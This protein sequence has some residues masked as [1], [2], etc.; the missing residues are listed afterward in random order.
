MTN[1]SKNLIDQI[2]SEWDL[3]VKPFR[4]AEKQYQ[5]NLKNLI[6]KHLSIPISFEEICNESWKDLCEAS[7]YDHP[8]DYLGRTHV[9][10]NVLNMHINYL[11]YADDE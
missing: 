6:L 11:E 10:E 1:N 4:E 7:M 8:R 5:L 2:N 3:V 9:L